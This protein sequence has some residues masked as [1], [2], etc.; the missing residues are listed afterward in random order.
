MHGYTPLDTLVEYAESADYI[1]LMGIHDIGS[2]GQPF[3]EAVFAKIEQMKSRFP[4]K[5][6]SVDGSVNAQ[7]IVRLKNTGADRFIV[8]SAI[9]LD[10][11]PAA[12]HRA[13]SLLIN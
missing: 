1:Q 4:N 2:Q 12:A 10:T 8:G 13:L 5:P 6:I 9:T 7:T 11:Q 3:D